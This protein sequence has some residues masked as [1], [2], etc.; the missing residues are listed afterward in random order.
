[1]FQDIPKN[2]RYTY[3]RVSSQSQQENSS[4][5]SQ[6]Q[7]FI[8]QGISEKNIRIEIGST[9]DIISERSIFYNLVDHELKENNLLPVIKINRC[10]RNTLEFLK[11][12]EKLFNKGVTF[13]S[14]DLPYSN[15][16]AINKLIAEVKHL[17]EN[18]KLANT[19]IAKITGRR[20]NITT[21]ILKQVLNYVPYN[22]LVKQKSPNDSK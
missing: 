10:S 8:K 20:P 9:V 13:I 11:L 22:P 12:Q 14:L 7:E 19:P 1:M 21:K 16:M 17:K 2:C 3:G 15:D 5:E 4:L 6:K 18:K